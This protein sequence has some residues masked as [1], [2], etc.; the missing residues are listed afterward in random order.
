MSSSIKNKVKRIINSLPYINRLFKELSEYKRNSWVPPGH[1]YSPVVNR[2]E[3]NK[4]KEWIFQKP[5]G[6][7]YGIDLRKE[8]QVALLESFTRYYDQMTF[9]PL[10]DPKHRYYFENRYFTYA[11]GTSLFLMLAHFKPS[12]VIEVGSGFS[13]ALMLDM[14]SGML[15]DKTELSFI[16]PY[17]DTRLRGLVRPGDKFNLIE[18]F[19]QDIE[20][21]FFKTLKANDVLFIDSSH[22]VKT[23]SELNYLFFEI[24]PVLAP[25]VIIHFHDIFYPFEYPQDWVNEGRSWNEAYF[26]RAFLMHN[27]DVDILLFTSY[28]QQ[29]HNAWIGKNLNFLMKDRASSLWLVKK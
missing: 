21:G 2:E 15:K 5:P 9:T 6:D 24:F 1:Y 18:R 10:Q 25:G 7:L 29:I 14:A 4:R 16:E 19:L 27:R 23:G 20:I 22:V 28:L 11:D 26:L 17:P 13:S 3:I 12:R 8:N